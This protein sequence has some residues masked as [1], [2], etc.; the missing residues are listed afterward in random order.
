MKRENLDGF[1]MI[2]A[3]LAFAIGGLIFSFVF[4][5][6]PGVFANARDSERRDDVLSVVNKL[7]NFQA[8]TN[9]GALPTGAIPANG[10]YID[11]D[12]IIFGPT[13]NVTWRDFYAGFFDENFLE[14]NG[15]RYNWMIVNC[16][17]KNI[18]D[19]CTNTKYLD[20]VDKT[21]GE[22]NNTLYFV[23]G[24]TCNGDAAILTPNNRMVAV[25]Y[26]LERAGTYCA[27]T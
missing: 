4:F 1:T 10:Q 2:E 20:F 11:G 7:K 23:I 5:A 21:F 14:P 12:S 25:L 13:T 3:I 18:G 24:A 26:K 6:L 17:A 22:N 19:E 9:R 15:S 8:N 27:N 16:G